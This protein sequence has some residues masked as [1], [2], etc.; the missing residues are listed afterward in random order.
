MAGASTKSP[1]ASYTF[2]FTCFYV[3]KAAAGGKSHTGLKT[4]SGAEESRTPGLNIANVALCQLSYRPGFFN[5]FSSLL[6]N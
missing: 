5:P 6:K 4:K 1:S 3:K 2:L